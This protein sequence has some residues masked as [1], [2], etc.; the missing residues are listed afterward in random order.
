MAVG[1]DAQQARW[2]P[3]IARGE[4]I[5]SL[6][7]M[8]PAGVFGPAGVEATATKRGD[9]YVVDGTKLLVAF[10]AVGRCPAHAGGD[11]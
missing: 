6:A 3:A 1:T 8:E 4:A 11:G 10:A 9:T 7:L 5:I 2:L